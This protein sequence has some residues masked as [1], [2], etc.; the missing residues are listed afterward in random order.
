[1]SND[2]EYIRMQSN[3]TDCSICGKPTEIAWGVPTINGDIVSNQFPDW[4][5]LQEGGNIH[6]CKSCYEKHERGEIATFDK[7]YIPLTDGFI[8]GTGI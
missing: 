8:G 1:M 7:Y 2:I 5:W 4:F 6:V 3:E